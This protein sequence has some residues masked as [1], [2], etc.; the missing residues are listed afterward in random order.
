M[1]LEL[2]F[3]KTSWHS[4]SPNPGCPRWTGK[5]VAY[6]RGHSITRSPTWPHF[7]PHRHAPGSIWEAND[8]IGQTV[9]PQP[10][11]VGCDRSPNGKPSTEN[12][13]YRTARQLFWRHKGRGRCNLGQPSSC[14]T[15][16]LRKTLL[17]QPGKHWPMTIVVW[18]LPVPHSGPRMSVSRSTVLYLQCLGK[19]LHLFEG[20]FQRTGKEKTAALI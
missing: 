17:L 19:T 6:M 8:L 20:I 4:N 14:A 12:K 9:W 5:G 10:L 2:L 16:P 3:C 11:V 13:W 7:L 15:F 1:L 18:V